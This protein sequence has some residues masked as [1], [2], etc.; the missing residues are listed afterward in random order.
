LVL[1][2]IERGD[3]AAFTKQAAA[4]VDAMP[5]H[6][7]VPNLLCRLAATAVSRGEI[8]RAAEWVIRLTRDHSRS[9]YVRETLLHFDAAAEE[10]PG[11]R[12][13]VYGEILGGPASAALRLDALFGLTEADLALGDP[14]GSQRAA[15]AFL[16]EAPAGDPRI[17]TTFARIVRIHEVQGRHGL[18]LRTAE[19]FLVRFPDE[20]LV[21]YV[22]LARGRLL[23]AEGKWES[24]QRSLEV[25]RNRGEPQVAAEAHF[26]LGETFW[27]RG[28]LD[29]AIAAYLGASRRYPQT[30]WAARGL[31]GAARS[32]LVR[33]MPAE[34]A[35]MLREITVQA[36]AEPALVEWARDGLQ[37]LGVEPIPG[38]PDRLPT[39]PGPKP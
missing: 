12:R 1:V 9:E 26:W 4:F 10:R 16:R 20:S 15:E 13:R 11:L 5:S 7:A 27:V 18:A 14:A 34:A 19:S 36:A 2:A 21:P 8:E 22:E 37:R 35:I 30:K 25:A 32:Y 28:D 38:T 24:A 17:P 39:V 29:A 3:E 33:G 23:V 6:D 31:Q